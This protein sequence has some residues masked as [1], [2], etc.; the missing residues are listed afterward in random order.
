[1]IQVAMIFARQISKPI[2]DAVM[3][4]G[5]SH[6]GFRTKFLIPIGKAIVRLTTRMRMKR[7]GLG[8]PTTAQHISETQA[9][10]QAS[11][12]VQQ[13]VLFAYSVGLFAGV[14]Y[15]T[16]LTAPKTLKT[17]EFELYKA[18]Q[19]KAYDELM[20][21]VT[22]LEEKI[23]KKSIF[24]LGS[25]SSGSNSSSQTIS[26]TQ[27]ATTTATVTPP[28]SVSPP[29]S[30]SSSPQPISP[31]QSQ[32]AP[33][34][35]QQPL[36]ASTSAPVLTQSSPPS[37]AQS[38][39]SKRP[40]FDRVSSL[41]LDAAARIVL[42]DEEHFLVMKKDNSIGIEDAVRFEASGRSLR[43]RPL[44]C[45]MPPKGIARF[46]EDIADFIFGRLTWR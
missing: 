18:E 1:M 5:K 14:Y 7:L 23:N 38:A 8:E 33:P 28:A 30:E 25:F 24:S 37:P 44:P 40:Q 13:S 32:P 16:A 3:R 6:P 42:S 17:E 34:S 12:L 27:T 31:S 41:P 11:E 9:L 39:P 45:E 35:T 10:E 26:T 4:Y 29:S 46:A 20:K 15:Y 19:Q 22:I 2:A 21:R 43:F 36:S